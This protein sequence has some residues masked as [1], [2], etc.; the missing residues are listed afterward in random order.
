MLNSS[1]QD[2]NQASAQGLHP[3][4]WLQAINELEAN[5]DT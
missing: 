5:G 1:I 4:S 3:H 2:H